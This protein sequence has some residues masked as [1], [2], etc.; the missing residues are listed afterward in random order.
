M[1]TLEKFI[2]LGRTLSVFGSDAPTGEVLRRAV[3]DNN[4]FTERDVIAAVRAIAQD[5]LTPQNLEQWL[6][7]YPTRPTS[8]PRDVLVFMA[9]NIPAVGFADL[10]CVLA[11][12]HRALVKYSSRDKALMEYIVQLLNKDFEICEY[13]SERDTPEALLAMGSDSTARILEERFGCIPR[14]V[15]SSRT[16]VA[17]LTGDESTADLDGLCRDIADYDGR[18]CRSVSHL[19][20]PSTY[21]FAPL[22]EALRRMR[23]SDKWLG[24]YR[25]TRALAQMSGTEVID[26]GTALLVAGDQPS[27][28]ISELHYTTYHDVAQLAEWVNTHDATL[29]CIVA[30]DFVHPRRVPFGQAQHPALWDYP[31]GTDTMEWL[32]SL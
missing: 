27:M 2:S 31:D 18:G 9:G 10:L 32:L 13:D 24:I 17:V 26:C 28:S 6:T 22:I 11:A 30:S 29:Q 21:D 19:L 14:L 15:R 1:Q 23:V 5:M 8:S 20:I 25:H 7:R 12:G 16:S 3:A 4:W